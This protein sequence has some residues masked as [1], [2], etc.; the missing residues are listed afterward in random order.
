MDVEWIDLV[1]T[2]PPNHTLTRVSTG[3]FKVQL[4]HGVNP[5]QIMQVHQ[6]ESVRARARARVRA[7]VHACVH[8]RARACVCACV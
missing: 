3:C 6:Q 5:G 1:L 8:A 4:P 7:C 2:P